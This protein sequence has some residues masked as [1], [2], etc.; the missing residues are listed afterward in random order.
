M[1]AQRSGLDMDGAF[2]R[3]RGYARRGGLRLSEVARQVVDGDLDP[4]VVL[5]AV[6]PVQ[7]AE[8]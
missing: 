3:L 8:A 1:L 7:G 2:D 5:A 4:D 6:G